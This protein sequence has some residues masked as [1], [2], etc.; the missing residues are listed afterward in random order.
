MSDKNVFTQNLSHQKRVT[1]HWVLQ[2]FALI[3]ITIAQ[4]AIYVNKERNGYPHYQTIH[5]IF[6]FVT[7]FL[8]LFVGTFGGVVTKYSYQLR[9]FVMPA[10]C[11]VG[12][13]FGGI[14]IYVIAIVTIFLGINQSWINEGD[15]NI[16]MGLAAAFVGTSFYV[17]NKSF[18][19]A[20]KRLKGVK[21][22][23]H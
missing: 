8:T 12:H 19:L 13:A 14:S 1:A 9:K 11:K 7:Y 10:K 3:L 5:S 15:K 22:L 2:A 18:K 4:S 23:K 16:K 6:G 21:T 17:V 20:V